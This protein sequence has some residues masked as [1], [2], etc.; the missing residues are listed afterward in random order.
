MRCAPSQFVT[1]LAKGTISTQ[2]MRRR[3]SSSRKYTPQ[4]RLVAPSIGGEQR[5][6]MGL[7]PGGDQTECGRKRWMNQLPKDQALP[8]HHPAHQV[9][10]HRKVGD[11]G[12]RQPAYAPPVRSEPAATS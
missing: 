9:G 4:Y 6:E 5:M 12:G 10:M 2:W 11:W 3:V 8:S 1:S 7:H